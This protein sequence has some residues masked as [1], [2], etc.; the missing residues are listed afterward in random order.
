VDQVT[1]K[2]YAEPLEASPFNMYSSL[3]L[4]CYLV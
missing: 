4:D 3:V 2:Q 1:A